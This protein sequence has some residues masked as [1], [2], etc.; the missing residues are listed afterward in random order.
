M[1]L[2]VLGI[3]IVILLTIFINAYKRV[4]RIERV[5]VTPQ[6]EIDETSIESDQVVKNHFKQTKPKWKRDDV[7]YRTISELYNQ[8]DYHF[9]KG[10]LAEAQKGFIKVIALKPSHAEANNKLGIIYIK[11]NQLTKAEA[12][13]RSLIEFYP[14]NP[15]YYSN[16]GRVLYNDKRYKPA[17]LAYEQAINLDPNRVER[18]LS[19]GEVYRQQGNL[20]KAVSSFSRVLEINPRNEDMYFLITDLLEEISAYEEAIAYL[21]A[22]LEYFPYNNKAKELLLEYRR[23]INLSPLSTEREGVRRKKQNMLKNTTTNH[24]LFKDIKP[25][26]ATSQTNFILEEE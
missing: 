23:R 12:I 5:K 13:Y 9:S 7:D 3:C 20:K 22:M 21:Q 18:Y 11:Q 17:A 25:G 4:R 16:L 6:K 15:I 26:E 10:E 1:P 24:T 2:L 14:Q 19:L 8:A